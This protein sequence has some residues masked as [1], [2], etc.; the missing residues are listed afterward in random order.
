MKNYFILFLFVILSTP[1]SFGQGF[2]KAFGVNNPNQQDLYD[3][4][5]DSNNTI[6]AS[7]TFRNISYFP[8]FNFYGSL[9]KINPSGSLNWFK[10]YLPTD[11]VPFDGLF[12]NNIIQTDDNSIYGFGVHIGGTDD[13]TGYYLI[14]F[15]NSGQVIWSKF[16]SGPWEQFS[17]AVYGNNAIYGIMRDTVV[18]FDLNGEIINSVKVNL[19]YDITFRSACVT[20][21][22]DII[23]TGDIFYNATWGTPVITFDQNL[24]PLSGYYYNVADGGSIYGTS[25]TESSDNKIIVGASGLTFAINKINGSVYWARSFEIHEQDNTVESLFNMN[26]IKAVNNEKTE[27]YTSFN[28]AYYDDNRNIE[29]IATAKL[30]NEG[31]FTELKAIKQTPF[32]SVDM[33]HNPYSL[34]VKPESNSFFIAGNMYAEDAGSGEDYH[35]NYLHKGNLNQLECGDQPVG[36]HFLI[37]DSLL[38]QNAIPMNL[39]IPTTIQSVTKQFNVFDVIPDYNNTYCID[40]LSLPTIETSETQVFPNPAKDVLNIQMLQTITEISVFDVLGKEVTVPRTSSNSIDVSGLSEGLYILK[41]ISED[42][43]SFSSKFIK[44]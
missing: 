18:K 2:Q 27:F 8:E 32:T 4:S 7:G 3:L 25:V 40:A 36:L 9:S 22:G 26:D 41:I 21:S 35:L 42:Q 1:F 24:N 10:A 11:A 14:K 20:S 34:H 33:F 15:N 38:T 6:Y 19:N 13:R 23:V 30:D 12:I 43:K 5:I 28:G 37:D 16:I 31:N 39:I 44:E 29:Y 17:H